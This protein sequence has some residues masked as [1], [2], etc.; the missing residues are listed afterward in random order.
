MN[1]TLLY[2]DLDFSLSFLA[3]GWDRLSR[4]THTSGDASGQ[5]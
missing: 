4:Q 2:A 5:A 1:L 3:C